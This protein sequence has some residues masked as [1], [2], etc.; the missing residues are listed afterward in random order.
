MSA[1]SYDVDDAFRQLRLFNVGD[2]SDLD[3]F[4]AAYVKVMK[5]KVAE[6]AEARAAEAGARAAAAAAGEV[7]KWLTRLDALVIGPGLV[8]LG[9]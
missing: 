5:E 4:E 9:R 3:E 7:A 2:D 1:W 6:K 8:G